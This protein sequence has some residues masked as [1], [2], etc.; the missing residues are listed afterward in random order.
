MRRFGLL[1]LLLPLG[2][3]SGGTESSIDGDPAWLSA[4][5]WDDGAA[6]ISVFRGRINW[7]GQWRDAEVRH[8]VV[9]EYLDPGELTKAEP[10]REDSIPVLK[11]NVLVSFT[12]GTYEYRQMCSL[13]F[14]R[15]TGALV[16][17][18]GS[19][20]EGCGASFQRWD[21]RGKLHYDTYWAGEGSGSRD[22]PKPRR[23]F[24]ENELPILAGL[25]A[26]QKIE[27]LPTLVKSSVRDR[28]REKANVA[29][30]GRTTKIGGRTYR[31]DA[32]GFLEGWTVPGREELRRVVRRK[33]YYWQKNRV[34]DEKLLEAK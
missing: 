14:D 2:P 33:L 25:L 21:R 28:S 20:Q 1:L 26:P 17:G 11:A 9:R 23:A 4:T 24:F 18:V 22:L 15:R 10:P 32:E 31:Y 12:T 27:V 13:F 3:A 8:Y 16:K 19:S 5:S 30:D 34:G 29:R 7:Y 6:R